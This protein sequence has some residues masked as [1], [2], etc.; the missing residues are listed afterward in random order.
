MKIEELIT[1]AQIEFSFGHANFGPDM[2]K[3]QVINLEMLKFACRYGTGHTAKCICTEL[4][5]ID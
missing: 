1:D 4:G 3:R 2:T 5:L